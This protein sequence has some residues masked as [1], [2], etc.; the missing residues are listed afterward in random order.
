MGAVEVGNG[1]ARGGKAAGPR[2]SELGVVADVSPLAK[3]SLDEAFGF[4]VGAGSV[5]PDR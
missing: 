4:A 2:S 3:S 1:A 5:D